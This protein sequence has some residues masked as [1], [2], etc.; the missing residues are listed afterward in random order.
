MPEQ[1]SPWKAPELS[2]AGARTPAAA[3]GDDHVRVRIES[4][5]DIVVAR[6]QGRALASRA[7]F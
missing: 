2:A 5:G 4:S 3:E 7:G 6:Q 1:P